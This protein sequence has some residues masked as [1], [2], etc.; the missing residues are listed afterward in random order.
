MFEPL[1]IFTEEAQKLNHQYFMFEIG[2]VHVLFLLD[3]FSELQELHHLLYLSVGDLLVSFVIVLYQ[4]L[5]QL[6]DVCSQ[7]FHFSYLLE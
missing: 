7:L 3:L 6:E 2:R 1:L 5:D 4:N